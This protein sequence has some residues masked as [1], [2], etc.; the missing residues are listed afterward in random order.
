MDS[1]SSSTD[2]YALMGFALTYLQSVERIL[3]FVTTFVL[4]DGE[5]LS[6]EKL[7]SL[8]A[9]EAKKTLGY[10]MFKIRERAQLFPNLD[11]LLGTYLKN[12]N[13]FIHSQSAI[14]GWDLS[15][16]EGV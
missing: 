10:F 13:D 14:P 7:Q 15:S 2:I 8:E 3:R 11:Q 16:K 5:N 4:Q 1:L 9:K 6:I 12:R